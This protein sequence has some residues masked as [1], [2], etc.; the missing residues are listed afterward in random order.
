MVCKERAVGSWNNVFF[1]NR[2]SLK[3]LKSKFMTCFSMVI[4]RNWFFTASTFKGT[5]LN[6]SA[7][8][9]DITKLY[10]CSENSPHYHNTSLVLWLMHFLEL[11][12][13]RILTYSLFEAE[14]DNYS[15]CRKNEVEMC[16]KCDKSFLRNRWLQR[17][18]ESCSTK[19]N[20]K[21]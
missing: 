5:F 17:H 15:S 3:K 8:H 19:Q 7:K 13:I 9:E 18:V 4:Y 20:Y 6:F 14:S 16:P 11:C 21:N 12:P 2:Q 1:T 10:I